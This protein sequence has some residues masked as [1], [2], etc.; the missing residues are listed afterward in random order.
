MWRRA[1][2]Q[3][4]RRAGGR[5]RDQPRS[6]GT[7]ASAGVWVTR[8]D[9]DL[10]PLAWLAVTA[11]VVVVLVSLDLAHRLAGTTVQAPERPTQQSR[12]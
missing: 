9:L 5:A 12:R 8:N 3:A 1:W 11:G 6:D 2:W 4:G 7:D 10:A